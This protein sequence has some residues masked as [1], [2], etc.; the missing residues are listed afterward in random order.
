[1]GKSRKAI[2]NQRMKNDAI[3]AYYMQKFASVSYPMFEWNNFGPYFDARFAENELFSRGWVTV[4]YQPE[5]ESFLCNKVIPGVDLDIYGNMRNNTVAAINGFQCHLNQSNSVIIYDNFNRAG[6]GGFS[7]RPVAPMEMLDN[8]VSEMALLHQSM[9]QNINSLGCPILLTG[10]D[11]QQLSLRVKMESFDLKLPYIFV[12]QDLSSVNEMKA[13]RTE[14]PNNIQSFANELENCWGEGMAVLGMSNVGVLKRAQISVDE[15]NS[16]NGQ[17]SMTQYGRLESRKA[18][19]KRLNE[20]FNSNCEIV[21]RRAAPETS[22]DGDFTA[23]NYEA[24]HEEDKTPKSVSAGER[25]ARSDG[26]DING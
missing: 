15:A 23:L 14:C 21:L 20:L 18:G 13:V 4:W 12:N 2:I 16:T 19:C 5:V 8:I 7:N 9:M 24:K 10:T 3:Y 11:D 17:T 6:F 26:G 22:P 25:G 1:M